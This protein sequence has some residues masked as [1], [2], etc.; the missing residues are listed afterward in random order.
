MFARRACAV[1]SAAA[2]A[3]ESKT[4]CQARQRT[5]RYAFPSTSLVQS[6]SVA[7]RED[8]VVLVS[9]IPCLARNRPPLLCGAEFRAAKTC[10]RAT[11]QKRDR[12]SSAA[13]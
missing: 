13:E 2:F 8:H 5:R 7:C 3:V 12:R 6:R 1:F 9:E 4:C 10:V 11:L